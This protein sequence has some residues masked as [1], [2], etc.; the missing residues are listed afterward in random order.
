MVGRGCGGGEVRDD[1]RLGEEREGG[2]GEVLL[3]WD[4]R[5]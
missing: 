5:E 1:V 2:G 3:R 4:L